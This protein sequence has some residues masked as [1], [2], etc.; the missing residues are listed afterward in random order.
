MRQ[1]LAAIYEKGVLRPVNPLV[2]LQ[3]GQKLTITL[4]VEE[5]AE[6]QRREAEFIKQMEA[7]GLLMHL[8]G[9]PPPFPANFRPVEIS[10]P[11]LSQTIIEDRE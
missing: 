10:G 7:E 11:P 1:T 9:P 2:G 5:N 3:E 6:L 4:E 8:P